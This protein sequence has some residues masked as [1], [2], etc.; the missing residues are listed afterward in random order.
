VYEALTVL[1]RVP[2]RINHAVHDVVLKVWDNGGG[3]AEIPSL[4]D[5]PV[6]PPF[7]TDEDFDV[8]VEEQRIALRS[9]SLSPSLSLTL[10]FRRILVVFHLCD[11]C[12][13]GGA[14]VLCGGAFC[15]RLVAI[16]TSPLT[17][18][19]Q[20]TTRGRLVG[21]CVADATCHAVRCDAGHRRHNWER[22]NIQ[23][24]NANLHSLRCDMR[25]KLEVAQMFRDDTMYFPHNLDFRG[26][27]YPIPPHLNHMGA[28]LNRFGDGG[29]ACRRMA[30]LRRWW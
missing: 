23:R 7:V 16:A 27:A 24:D 4:F 25:L 17:L 20:S 26:R 10:H 28:D 21:R 29:V 13:W 2:H 30:V 6:P 12:L 14:P 8:Q 11:A 18:P 15:G 1:G 19:T 3:I 5:A 9:V 22:S